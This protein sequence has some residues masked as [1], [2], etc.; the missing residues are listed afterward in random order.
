M[1]ARRASTARATAE[2]NSIAG[3]ERKNGC[4]AEFAAHPRIGRERG[5]GARQA[6]RVNHAP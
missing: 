6:N 4:A 3:D 1:A 2:E 5:L